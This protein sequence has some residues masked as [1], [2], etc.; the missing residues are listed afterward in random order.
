MGV[1][2]IMG[3]TGDAFKILRGQDKIKYVAIVSVQ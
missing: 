1:S 3:N 2:N